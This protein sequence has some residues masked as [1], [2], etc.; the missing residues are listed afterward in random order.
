MKKSRRVFALIL[1]LC[2]AITLFPSIGKSKKAEAA[3]TAKL[4][5]TNATTSS[6]TVK[7]KA[8]T[9]ATKYY[10]GWGTSYS[11]ASD[12]A[13]SKKY[14]VSKDTLT[15]TVKNRNAGNEVYV[16]VYYT[17]KDSTYLK[18]VD[19]IVTKTLSNVVS[20]FKLSSYFIPQSTNSKASFTV[21]WRQPGKVDG[22]QYEIYGASSGS[23]LVSKTLEGSYSHSCSYQEAKETASYKTRVRS[24]V[25][26]NGTKK[27]S[28]WSSYYYVIMQPRVTSAKINSNGQLT[29]KWNKNT[30]ASSYEIWVSDSSVGGAIGYKKLGTATGTS[31][32]FSKFDGAAFSKKKNYYIIVRAVKTLSNNKKVYSGT[33]YYY[34]LD[35]E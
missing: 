26:C 32:T 27:Y 9:G 13:R 8:Q 30:Y 14:P 20:S 6:V 24:Y 1:A 11:A 16:Y 25:N 17:T 3:T 19:G 2:F 23:K 10:I 18:V 7:W 28:A 22:Y 15:Y 21:S 12:L 35:W 5:Q 4:Y 34:T 33:D 29:V 31:K